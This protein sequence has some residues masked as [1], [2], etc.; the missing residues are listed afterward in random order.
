MTQ[1]ILPPPPPLTAELPSPE[2]PDLPDLPELPEPPR[3]LAKPPRATTDHPTELCPADHPRTPPEPARAARA[4]GTP[5]TRSSLP[6]RLSESARRS[7]A[8]LPGPPTTPNHTP[9]GLPALYPRLPEPRESAQLPAVDLDLASSRLRA[10]G[11]PLAPTAPA[12][13]IRTLVFAPEPTRAAWVERELSR[14]PITI[15]IGRSVR[16]IIAALTLDPPPRPEVLIVDFDALSPEELTELH[17]VRQGGWFGRL[18][19][20]GHVPPELRAPLG[21]DHVF[22]AP[23]VRDTLLDCVAGT[24]HAT[25]TTACPVIPDWDDRY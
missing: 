14:P 6:G 25:V 8:R 16:T 21:V 1:P 7:A 10:R 4:S 22:A 17:E 2:L 19:G 3:R 15:L 12:G 5:I 24:K 23:L 11:T 9:A 18:I 13:Q 20:L